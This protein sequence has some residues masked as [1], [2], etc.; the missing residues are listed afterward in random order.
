MKHLWLFALAFLGGAYLWTR[1]N[2]PQPWDFY[3]PALPVGQDDLLY[4]N[5]V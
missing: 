3:T 4:L 5:Q 1:A 2:P